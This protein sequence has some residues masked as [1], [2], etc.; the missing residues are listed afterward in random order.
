MTFENITKDSKCNC[1]ESTFEDTE[2][3]YARVL[4]KQTFDDKD[5]LTKWEKEHRHDDCETVCSD[6]KCLSISKVDSDAVKEEI[7]NIYKKIMNLS[8][9]YK[10]G[11]LLFKIKEGAG[12][13]KKTP[14]DDNPYHHDLYKSDAFSID[15]IIN[16]GIE[17]LNP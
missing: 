15:S 1:L 11:V 14:F 16:S 4:R 13:Y 12:V 9:K 17:I 8:P 3:L 6:L 2:S 7:V 5:F 10:K